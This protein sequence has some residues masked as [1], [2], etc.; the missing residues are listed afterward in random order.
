MHDPTVWRRDA[1]PLILCCMNGN[2]TN[3]LSS[4]VRDRA[5]YAIQK[6]NTAGNYNG[7]LALESTGMYEDYIPFLI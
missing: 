1:I 6:M 4:D 7:I 5:V 3:R 2:F